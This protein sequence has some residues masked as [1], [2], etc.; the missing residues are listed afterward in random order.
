MVD[1]W[2]T[3][4]L[5]Y[6]FTTISKPAWQ[7]LNQMNPYSNVNIVAHSA[8][9]GDQNEPLN[10]SIHCVLVVNNALEFPMSL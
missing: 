3:I 4:L 1:W 10:V 9:G 6:H 2:I 5:N 8:H 7:L